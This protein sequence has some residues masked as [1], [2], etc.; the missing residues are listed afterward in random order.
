MEKRAM[1]KLK[2]LR[3]QMGL[4]QTE[5]AE[6]CG[7][8]CKNISRYENGDRNPGIHNYRRLAKAL[9]CR[10]SDLIED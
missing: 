8:S 7:I 5:L 4:T 2:N 6:K 10:P 9:N 1:V 3:K